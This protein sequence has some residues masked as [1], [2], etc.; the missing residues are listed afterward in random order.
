MILLY[1]TLSLF[2]RVRAQSQSW[3]VAYEEMGSCEVIWFQS[4]IRAGQ[5]FNDDDDD[6]DLGIFLIWFGLV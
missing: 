4:Q 5:V 1:S 3:L 6:D 2:T